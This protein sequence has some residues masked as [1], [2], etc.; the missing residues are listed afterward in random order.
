MSK[1]G[2]VLLCVV[3]VTFCGCQAFRPYVA[4]WFPIETSNTTSTTSGNIGSRPL[5]IEHG[6]EIVWHTPQGKRV[7]QYEDGYFDGWFVDNIAAHWEGICNL[8]EARTGDATLRQGGNQ[9]IAVECKPVSYFAPNLANVLATGEPLEQVPD[10]VDWAIYYPNGHV[11]AFWHGHTADCVSPY[12]HVRDPQG[13]DRS[14][15]PANHPHCYN[16]QRVDIRY[17]GVPQGWDGKCKEVKP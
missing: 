13:R 1:F 16:G 5:N 6:R 12:Y 2:S 7:V 17:T 14:S 8:Y 11:I 3:A 10:K 4:K 15:A 9:P